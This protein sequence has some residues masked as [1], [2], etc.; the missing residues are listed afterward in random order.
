MPSM[1][2]E[3][4][5]TYFEYLGRLVHTFSLAEAI[6]FKFL[7]CYTRVSDKTARAIFSGVRLKEGISF[8]RRLMEIRS[9]E[10]RGANLIISND[11][12]S[13]SLDRTKEIAVSHCGLN[14]FKAPGAIQSALGLLKTARNRATFFEQPPVP[15]GSHRFPADT[16][17]TTRHSAGDL[18][19]LTPRASPWRSA[20]SS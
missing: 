19:R 16:L 17:D 2:D 3:D 9:A 5:S 11:A 20:H 6:L 1:D 8:I 7:I 15:S 4:E 13:L 18:L 10:M 14:L 12:R